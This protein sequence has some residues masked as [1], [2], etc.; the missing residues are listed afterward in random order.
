M[1]SL[2]LVENDKFGIGRN[3]NSK[4]NQR[5]AQNEV[6]LKRAGEQLLLKTVFNRK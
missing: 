6:S 5:P 2:E 1:T 4:L 3:D